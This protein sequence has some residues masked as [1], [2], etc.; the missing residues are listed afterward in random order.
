M[1]VETGNGARGDLSRLLGAEPVVVAQAAPAAVVADD[2]FQLLGVVSPRASAAA[3]EGLALIAVDGKAAKAFR[4]GSVVDGNTVL[5]AVR[6]RGAS[7]GP[8]GGTAN[9]ALEIAPPAAAAV[10]TL[11]PAVE[12]QPSMP[13]APGLI[14]PQ[15]MGGGMPVVPNRARAV[16]QPQAPMPGQPMTGRAGPGNMQ[17]GAN[18]VQTQ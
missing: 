4:V 8:R 15:P 3:R 18:G 13:R 7:L 16:M 12:G 1:V 2:R 11:P 6:A 5:L 10:G 9:V 17:P 14:P